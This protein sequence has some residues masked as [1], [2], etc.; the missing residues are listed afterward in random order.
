[1]WERLTNREKRLIVVLLAVIIIVT[2]YRFLL[3]GQYSRWSSLKKEIAAGR[4]ALL[5]DKKTTEKLP[6]LQEQAGRLAASLEEIRRKFR[7]N[8]SDGSAYVNLGMLLQKN[9]TLLKVTPQPV[10]GKGSYQV[11][12]VDL[13]LRGSYLAL[14]DFIEAL[15]KM[16]GMAEITKLEMTAVGDGSYPELDSRISLVLYSVEETAPGKVPGQWET[17]RFDMFSPVLQ[18]LLDRT[19]KQAGPGISGESAASETNEASFLP[20]KTPSYHFPVK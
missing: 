2:G 16:P 8:L 6:R 13:E 3:A 9:V 20:G 4:T 1:M 14:L 15:E 5:R 17:G 11:L 12:P 18:Y 7:V 10:V 19:E